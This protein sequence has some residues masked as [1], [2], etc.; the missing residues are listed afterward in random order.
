MEAVI[1]KG[2]RMNTRFLSKGMELNGRSKEYVLKRLGEIENL[3]HELSLYEIETD[4]DKKG[5][6]RVEVNVREPHKLHRGEETSKSVEGSID[7]V[8]DKLRSHI[9]REKDK[10]RELRERGARSIKKK[11]VLDEAA[12]F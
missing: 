8:I 9:V 10:R 5:F 7:M 6:Y 12:R 4:L 2:T 1:R 3:F 11:A